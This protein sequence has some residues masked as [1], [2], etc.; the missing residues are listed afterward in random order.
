LFALNSAQPVI[1]FDAYWLSEVDVD[2]FGILYVGQHRNLYW[3][4]AAAAQ[5]EY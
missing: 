1:L 3:L 2:L 4:F 5:L